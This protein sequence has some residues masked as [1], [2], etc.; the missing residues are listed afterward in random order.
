MVLTCLSLACNMAC[1]NGVIPGPEGEV[2]MTVGWVA[3]GPSL[4]QLQAAAA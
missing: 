2:E 1:S 4:Q 3:I